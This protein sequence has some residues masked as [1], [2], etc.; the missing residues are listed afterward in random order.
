MERV[1]VF[2]YVRVS[3]YKQVLKG[4]GIDTQINEIKKH[5]NAY[6]LELVLCI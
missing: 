6:N 5:C 3:T 1:Q 4:H 2:G